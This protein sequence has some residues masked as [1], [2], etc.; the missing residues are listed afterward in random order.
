[1]ARKKVRRKS[2]RRPVKL[3]GSY[4]PAEV[5]MAA[6]GAAILILIVALIVTAI[7]GG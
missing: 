7:A 2:A 6:L 1:M 3:F 5:F 4:T